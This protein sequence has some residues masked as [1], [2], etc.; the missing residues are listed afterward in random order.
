MM[1]RHLTLKSTSPIYPGKRFRLT[2]VEHHLR[3]KFKGEVTTYPA[4]E[5]I[6]VE[7]IPDVSI[8]RQMCR[9]EFNRGQADS[10]DYRRIFKLIGVCGVEMFCC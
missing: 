10:R 7:N 1:R 6:H 4:T 5:N 8:A 2:K 9:L 3:P